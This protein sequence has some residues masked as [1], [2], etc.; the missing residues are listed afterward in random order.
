MNKKIA[1]FGKYLLVTI[2]V[3]FVVIFIHREGQTTLI[4]ICLE[5]FI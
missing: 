3:G 1:N 4:M 2:T 5:E